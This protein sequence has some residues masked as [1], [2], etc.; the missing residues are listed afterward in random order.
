MVVETL[1]VGGGL[2]GLALAERLTREGF[3]FLL[4]EAQD[5]LGGRILTKEISGGYFDFGPAWFWPGQPR[6]AALAERFGL[7]V[8]EQFSTGALVFQDRFGGVERG[9]G[10][11]SMQGSYRIDGGMGRL[12]EN[13]GGAIDPA[14]VRPGTRLLSLSRTDDGVIARLKDGDTHVEVTA[15]RV[16]LA[17]PPRVIADQIRFEPSL[18]ADQMNALSRIPTWMAGQAKIVAI[19]DSPHW[20]EAGLSGDAMSQRGPMVEIHDASPEEGG[21]YA[22][23][24]FVGVPFDARSGRQDDLLEMARAQL[25]DMFGEAMARPIAIELQDW[26]TI[27][28]IAVAQDRAPVQSHPHYGLPAVL[29]DIWEG[30]VHLS[31]TETGRD[32]GGFLEGA[33]EAAD[34]TAQR[35]GQ[36]RHT[37]Q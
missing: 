36:V 8:F 29:Q 28:E 32:F 17:V 37:T 26:A 5:R 34:M 20:R 14:N 2:S 18:S 25:V 21:P 10:F 15:K 19:Y 33:L 1:I 24:G 4:V 22:L 30:S 12:I 3:D 23:F 7:P 9:R 27:P 11:A 13:L 6:M 35:L 16:V 31:S